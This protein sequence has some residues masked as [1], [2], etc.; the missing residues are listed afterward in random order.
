MNTVFTN[1]IIT[2]YCACF[3]CTGTANQPTACGKMPVAGVTV[4]APRSI[5]FGTVVHI[6][7]IGQ[8]TVQDRLAR[9]YD[10]RWDV[11]LPS[12][13]AAKRFGLQRRTVTILRTNT[14]SP[15]KKPCPAPPSK[16]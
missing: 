13:A 7:G 6:E 5:P 3:L 10:S 9:R 15:P 8:R 11:F 14:A 1:A 4:A 12:H 2:A 16:S